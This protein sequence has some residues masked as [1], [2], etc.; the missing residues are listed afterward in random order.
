MVIEKNVFNVSETATLLGCG[1]QKIYQL[2]H[3][4]VLRAYK[5][6]H[7]RDWRVPEESIKNYMA[8]RL[9]VYD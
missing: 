9:N 4:K 8:A 7:G 2:I 5:N 3:N 6:Y 1:S